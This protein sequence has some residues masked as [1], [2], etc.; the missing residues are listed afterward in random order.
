M[1]K[2]WVQMHQRC[3]N[4]NIKAFKDYGE[5][6]IEVCLEWDDF[7]VF[8]SDVGERPSNR[9]TLDRI[10]NNGNYCSDNC[11]WSTYKEQHR[12]ARSNHMITFNGVTKCRIEWAEIT[13]I[14]SDTIR[15][16][17]RRFGWSVEKALTT[18]PRPC[19]YTTNK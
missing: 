17:I 2:Q 12:N 18:P 19:R 10:D 6:G 3:T 1:Y 14:N 16:R 7:S 13:G 11:K 8:L 15:A 9:H 4:P 5:R